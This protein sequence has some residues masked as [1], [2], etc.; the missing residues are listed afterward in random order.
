[1]TNTNIHMYQGY[2][3]AAEV[4]AAKDELHLILDAPH[5]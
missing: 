2:G 1:M 3:D 5:V 4:H